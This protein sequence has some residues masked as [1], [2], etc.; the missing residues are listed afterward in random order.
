MV[1]LAVLAVPVYFLLTLVNVWVAT[2]WDDRDPTDAIVVL[3][4]A[5]YNGTPSPALA[6]RLDHAFELWEQKVAP[7]IVL[8]GSKQA[9][10]TFTEAY[11]GLIYLRAKGVPEKDLV[12]I[13]T[14][15]STY[16][17]LAASGRELKSRRISRV[18][19][20]SDPYHSLRVTGIAEEVGLV[21]LVSPTGTSATWGQMF[22]ETVAV[23][24]GR[25]FGYRRVTNWLG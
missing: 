25:I 6:G 14:G 24:L 18:T 9:G 8:T 17:S 1:W 15:T 5:Q 2:G 16:E 22:R 11:V 3:G 20:V 13:A 10:D 12:V 21:P 23:G 4:A 19:L 7:M